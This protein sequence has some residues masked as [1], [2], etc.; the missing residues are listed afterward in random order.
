MYEN[1][2]LSKSL[3]GT[4]ASLIESPLGGKK[5][6]VGPRYPTV[7]TPASWLRSNP[8]DPD[9]PGLAFEFEF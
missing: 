8:T 5:P 3:V 2:I 9:L 4:E 6:A 7:T 1:V